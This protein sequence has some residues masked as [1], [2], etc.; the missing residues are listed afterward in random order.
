MAARPGISSQSHF[1]PAL[2]SIRVGFASDATQSLTQPAALGTIVLTRGQ[3]A[4]AYPQRNHPGRRGKM[5]ASTAKRKWSREG[6]RFDHG[7][8]S[9]LL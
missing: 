3:H 4:Q 5:F 8:M 7:I 9:P 2:E 1:P 6:L